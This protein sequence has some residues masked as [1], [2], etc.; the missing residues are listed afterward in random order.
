MT[1]SAKGS[2]E[3]PGRNVRA[4]TGLNRSLL[5]QAHGETLWHFTY[6]CARFG[7]T[8]HKKNPAYSSQKCSECGHIA[9][10][11][12]TDTASFRC[13][14]CGH[15]MNA[16]TN[17]ALNILSAPDWVPASA[18]GSPGTARRRQCHKTPNEA[19]THLYQAAH[20]A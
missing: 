3:E 6:K 18:G 7:G 12:R 16:H 10:E 1:R 19:S 17:A 5:A 4:K 13:S 15:S 2:I 9:Q 11:N 8:H 20:A 14:K